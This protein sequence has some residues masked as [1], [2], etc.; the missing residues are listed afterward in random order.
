MESSF[1]FR[2]LR[3]FV[4]PSDARTYYFLPAAPDLQRDSNRRPMITMIDAGSTGYV[5]FTARWAAPSDS[6]EALRREIAAS[7]HDPDT[8]GIRLSFAPVSS[9]QCHV[10]LGDGC[11]AFQTIATS[12]TS[13]VPPYDALFNL[14]IDNERLAHIRNAV[15]G[16]RGF[17]AIEYAAD[18]LVPSIGRA[19]FSADARGLMTWLRTHRDSGRS[20]RALLEEAVELGLASVTVDTPEHRGGGDAAV[21]LFER[22]L[23]QV[24]QVVPRLM[25]EGGDG[26]IEV[27]ATVERGAPQPI[28][29]FADVGDLVASAS[30]QP[31]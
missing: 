9:L 13:R 11:G 20:M 19:M 27:E 24:A 2:D 6:V 29:A 28:R 15:G 1:N 26:I 17:L 4:D 23:D 8:S 3:C 12:T 18:L 30:I 10:L 5:M 31:S 21:E 7:Y 25:A 22:V 16:K 14:T